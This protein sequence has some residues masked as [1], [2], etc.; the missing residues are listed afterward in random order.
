MN[1]TLLVSAL[2]QSVLVQLPSLLTV[3]GCMVFVVTRWNRNPKV[4]LTT[5]IGLVLIFLCGSFISL[6]FIFVRTSLI[7]GNAYDWVTVSVILRLIYNSAVAIAFIPLLAA[8][9]MQRSPSQ[10]SEVQFT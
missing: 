2:V 9:F 3:A 7:G 1:G 8:I 6:L 5:L 10:K 4:A